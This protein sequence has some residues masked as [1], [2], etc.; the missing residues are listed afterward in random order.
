MYDEE[1]L[2]KDFRKGLELAYERES[3]KGVYHPIVDFL[4]IW[5]EVHGYEMAAAHS[6]KALEDLVDEEEDAK[7]ALLVGSFGH[8]FRGN[9]V[10]ML[11]HCLMS[12]ALETDSSLVRDGAYEALEQW[13]VDDDVWNSY[14]PGSGDLLSAS[15]TS[16]EDVPEED[17]DESWTLSVGGEYHTFAMCPPDE[18]GLCWTPGDETNSLMIGDGGGGD[19]VVGTD[20]AP[21]F[22]SGFTLSVPCIPA[23]YVNTIQECKTSISLTCAKKAMPG[24][25]KQYGFSEGDSLALFEAVQIRELREPTAGF[26][27]EVVQDQHGPVLFA[28]DDLGN[29]L[30]LSQYGDGRWNAILWR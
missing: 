17:E 21:E 19:F 25:L 24:L 30:Q 8:T 7:A 5:D 28:W 4:R 23:D 29:A 16:W 22:S 3:S 27:G 12:M 10:G 6:I 2:T 15:G 18:V 20:A 26:R 11:G 13:I 9:S 1:Q 14:L